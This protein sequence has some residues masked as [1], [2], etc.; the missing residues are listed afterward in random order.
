MYVRPL[1]TKIVS[2]VA[3]GPNYGHSGGRKSFFCIFVFFVCFLKKITK[4]FGQKII[5]N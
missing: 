3:G 1:L 4:T 2:C 5:E